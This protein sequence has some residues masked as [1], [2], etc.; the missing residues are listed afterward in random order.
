MNT[1]KETYT[2]KKGSMRGPTLHRSFLLL[3]ASECIAYCDTLF[4][5]VADLLVGARPA[6]PL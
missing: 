1:L 4:E 6:V 5:P 2:D 3:G